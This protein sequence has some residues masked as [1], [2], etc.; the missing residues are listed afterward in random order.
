[1]I[2]LTFGL[3]TVSGSGP[4]GP[5]VY[6]PSIVTTEWNFIKLILSVYH[7]NDVMHLRFGQACCGS[8]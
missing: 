1:M 2:S 5:L 3:F 4:L 7:Y 8:S 6:S